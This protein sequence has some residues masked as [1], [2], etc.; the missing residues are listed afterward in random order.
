MKAVLH[1]F[2]QSTKVSFI[3]LYIL[4][5]V[6]RKGVYNIWQITWSTFRSGLQLALRPCHNFVLQSSYTRLKWGLFSLIPEIKVCG[7]FSVYQVHQANGQPARRSSTST[8]IYIFAEKQ[9]TLWN[10][11]YDIITRKEN[12][13][14]WMCHQTLNS[15]SSSVWK[16]RNLMNPTKVTAKVCRD[17]KETFILLR[18]FCSQNVFHFL[19]SET[20]WDTNTWQT[21]EGK[22]PRGTQSVEYMLHLFAMTVDGLNVE[23]GAPGLGWGEGGRVGVLKRGVVHQ[24]FYPQQI[25]ET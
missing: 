21:E 17:N 19:Q 25:T 6:E 7:V 3:C 2:P 18:E 12:T 8:H 9:L 13:E 4:D 15:K 5:W 1:G 22:I 24:N 20:A 14:Q 10:H 11:K 23:K 16:N